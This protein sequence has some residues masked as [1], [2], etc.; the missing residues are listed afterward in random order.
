MAK[1]AK[2]SGATPAAPA[3]SSASA[4]ASSASASA[5]ASS[6]SAAPAAAGKPKEPAARV[7]KPKAP[8]QT[9]EEKGKALGASA[10]ERAAAKYNVDEWNAEW[11]TVLAQMPDEAKP[12]GP[13]GQFSWTSHV[14][15]GPIHKA[16]RIEVILRNKGFRVATPK[17]TKAENPFTPWGN[18]IQAAWEEA[19]KKAET[20]LYA[21]G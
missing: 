19:K 18:N 12:V 2:A 3:A 17:M 13:H 5:A 21:Q 8:K 10:A 14:T 6:A 4:A 11:A 7:A 16:C 20:N 15:V 1:S 9:A